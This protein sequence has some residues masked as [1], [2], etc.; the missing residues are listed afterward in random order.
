MQQEIDK[1]LVLLA[2][3]KKKAKE[4]TEKSVDSEARRIKEVAALNKARDEDAKKL[5]QM[6]VSIEMIRKKL[7]R[8]NEELV[9]ISKKLKDSAIIASLS[10][11][12][13]NSKS[14]T[15]VK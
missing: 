7:D 13:V 1:V 8:K 6:E 15:E 9:A 10:N 3:A 5:R 14:S 4:E 12:K 2:A 11:T